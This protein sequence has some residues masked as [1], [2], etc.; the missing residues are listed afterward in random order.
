MTFVQRALEV[1]ISLSDDPYAKAKSFEGSGG[2]NELTL[3]GLRMSAKI[4]KAGGPSDC[5]M[6]LTIYGMTS[7]QMDQLSTLGMQINL[8]PKN[9]I[10][11]L[12]GDKETGMTTV[13][14]GYILT[15]YAD[16]KGQPEVPFR[17]TAH[18]GLPQS[19]ISTTPTS[20]K[21]SADVAD[22]MSGL[23]SRMGLIF[24]N[25]GVSGKVASPY[26]SGSLR[27]QAQTLAEAA[28]ISMLI[29]LGVLSIWPR[30]GNRTGEAVEV[31]KN[32]GMEGYPC[33]TN[34][35]LIIETLFNKQ[36]Q[37]GKLIKVISTLKPANGKWSVYGLNYSLD[38]QVPG[39]RWHTTVMAY[40]PKY[41]TPV[42]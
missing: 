10:V 5:T 11:L 35:G 7:S 24:E 13:F 33:Y 3:S 31:S 2:A 41:P 12:A 1:T 9:P 6:D 36:I 28:G 4:M 42:L 38:C 23:A 16:Y 25:N 15:A 37:F 8:T 17:I 27:T 30:N 19:V 34:Y 21:G 40:N 18:A 32:T 14:S 39:G 29:D 20:I 26:L 22:A